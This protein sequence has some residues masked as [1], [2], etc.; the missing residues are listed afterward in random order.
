MSETSVSGG[1][2][3]DSEER[4]LAE[5]RG[6]SRRRILFAAGVVAVGLA[7]ATA[8]AWL[9]LSRKD[10]AFLEVSAEAAQLQARQQELPV[11]RYELRSL[12]SDGRR[13]RVHL[14]IDTPHEYALDVTA[15]ER[16]S[17]RAA[18]AAREPSRSLTRVPHTERDGLVVLDDETRFRFS[19]F[20][21]PC[22]GGTMTSWRLCPEGAASGCLV[23]PLADRCYEGDLRLVELYRVED[24]LWAVVERKM[25][26][27]VARMVGGAV[28]ER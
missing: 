20:E 13:V 14:W 8:F 21:E 28:L 17:V 7:M 11:S 9:Q 26:G 18:R 6:S 4:A 16:R 15:G 22:P 12:S 23:A 19:T 2:V 5:R 25:G 27:R 3:H 10:A 1:S 24:T